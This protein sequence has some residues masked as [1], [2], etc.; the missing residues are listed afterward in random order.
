L[1]ARFSSAIGRVGSQSL[2]LNANGRWNLGSF[3]LNAAWRE[4]WTDARRTIGSGGTITGDGGLRSNSFSFDVSKAGFLRSNDRIG[5]RFA[6]PTRVS[7]GGL[8]LNVPV[9]FDFFEHILSELNVVML[10]VF[11]HLSRILILK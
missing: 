3:N 1:G 8:D 6:Q 5:F 10:N 9:S 7:S 4:G 2:F 11:Q